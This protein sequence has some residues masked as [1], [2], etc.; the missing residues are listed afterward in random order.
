MKYF[1]RFLVIAYCEYNKPVKYFNTKHTFLILFALIS[2]AFVTNCSTEKNTFINRTFHSTHAKYN[3]FFNANE[4]I[5]TAL[6][7]FENAYVENYDNILPVFI[8]PN[9]TESKAFYPPMDTASAKCER[10]IVKHQ[11]PGTKTG[12][13]KRVEWAKWIDENWMTR[14]KSSFYKKDYA[15]AQDIFQFVEKTYPSNTSSIMAKVWKAKVLIELGQYTEAKRIL[16]NLLDMQTELEEEEKKEKE[17]KKEETKKPS[18]SKKKTKTK[19]KKP[20][21][22]TKTDPE[23]KAELPKNFDQELWPIYADLYLRTKDYEKAK[24]ALEKSIELVEKRAFK[25]RL[26]FILAQLNH[27]QG[28]QA[29]SDLY[30]EVVKRNPKY[31]MAFNAKI[32]KALAFSGG[33]SRKIKAELIKMLKDAK[34]VSFKDQIY[35]ALGEIELRENNI[36]SALDYYEKS[37]ASNTTNPN[38]KTKSFLKLGDLHYQQKNYIKAQQYYDSTMTVL[39]KTHPKFDEISFRNESLNELVKHLNNAVGQDSLLKLCE[40]SPNDLEKKIFELIEAEEARIRLEEEKKEMEVAN[41]PVA[42]TTGST[43]FWPYD[44]NLKALGKNEFTKVWGQIKNEDDW[45]RSDKSST[46]ESEAVVITETKNP[47]LTPEYYLKNLPCNDLDAKNKASESIVQGW[48]G[49]AQVYKNKLND[50][51]EAIAAFKKLDKYL[52]HEKAIASLYQLYLIYQSK[53]NSAEATIYKNKI[54]TNYSDSEYAKMLKD[55][56][57]YQNSAK[58]TQ[59][60]EKD[61]E[62]IY[63]LFKSGNYNEVIEKCSQKISEKDNTYICKYLYLKTFATA[64][65][66]PNPSDLSSVEDALEELI[67]LCSDEEIKTNAKLLLDRL[68]NQQSVM[69]AKSGASNYIYSSDSKH[70]F[71][72]VFPNTAGSV[73]QAKIKVSDFNEASFSTKSLETKSSFI[74]ADNQVISVKLFDNKKAAMDYYLAFKVNKTIVQSLNANY[75]YFVITE[76]NFAALFVEKD[77]AKYIEFFQKNYLD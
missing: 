70:L 64:Y 21:T 11:M 33:D 32:N 49:A 66:N 18:S 52:P 50:E 37:V 51:P 53:G 46:D 69:D 67:K 27:Q 28:N 1:W 34:N 54:L 9:E 36:P 10:V 17:K 47:K 12:N 22:K 42:A 31:D 58:E 57:Y 8:Y 15:N 75:Q 48:Y 68:R 74:D 44:P 56:N 3:G 38:Q 20:S 43:K 41:T 77:L 19:G 16:D 29:A 72:L 65:C 24:E 59:K 30:G 14:G 13:N 60:E 61:Y 6:K 7:D 45:R 62:A 5:A 35:Y 55:P 23:K 2:I 39:E 76:K 4:I 71:I 73:N 26:I 40:L 25:T 63:S